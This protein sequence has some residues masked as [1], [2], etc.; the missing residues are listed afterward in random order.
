MLHKAARYEN[1]WENGGQS[2]THS[3]VYR[4]EGLASRPG[5]YTPERPSGPIG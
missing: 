5:R 1:I 3:V 4:G 2:S